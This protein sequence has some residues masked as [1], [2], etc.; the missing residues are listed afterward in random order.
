MK[1]I[2]PFPDTAKTQEQ[3]AM[4]IARLDGGNLDAAGREELRVWLEQDRNHQLALEQMAQVWGAMDSLAILAELFP[5]EVD[6]SPQTSRSWIAP[7]AACAAAVV[8]AV[9][10]YVQGV[11]GNF[12]AVTSEVSAVAAPKELIY[13][14]DLGQQSVVTLEDGSILTLNTKSE[15]HV[16]FDNAVRN[17]YL[18]RGQAHF[19]VA[20]NP[21]RPFVVHAGNGWVRAI[22]TA[23]DVRLMGE[24]VE[25]LVEEG[26]VEVVPTP[27]LASKKDRVAP[28]N[29]ALVA[30]SNAQNIVLKSGGTATYSE[31]V[32]Q[33]ETLPDQRVEQRLAWRKGKWMF[34]GETL[35]EVLDEVARYSDLNI[36]IVDPKIASLRVG[37][38]FDIGDVDSL[39]KALETGFGVTVNRDGKTIHLLRDATSKQG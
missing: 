6:S 3:A 37:G 9:G 30:A 39:M 28:T 20:K 19:K 12:D 4:W 21:D 13:Q 34:Q 18:S 10:L 33:T 38:Y 32:T 1:T 31:Q 16:L 15:V 35:A 14:T 26:V 36:V 22:G 11:F 27:T 24:Q 23:F 8:V 25:V 7:F 29:R 5:D 2:I 17:V